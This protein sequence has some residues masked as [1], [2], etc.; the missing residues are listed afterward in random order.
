MLTSGGWAQEASRVCMARAETI[1]L[2]DSVFAPSWVYPEG[3]I[4]YSAVERLLDQA[5]MALTGES[6][7]RGAWSQLFRPNDRVG[8]QLD[9][10]ALPVHQALLEAVMRRLARAGVSTS[11]IIVYAGE[12]SALFNAGYALRRGGDGVQV[13]GTDAEGFRGGLSRI[14]LDYCTAIINLARLRVDPQVG[15]CG[16]LANSL[17]A[18]PHV[19]RAR[20]Q[21][22]PQDLAAAAARATLRR[23]TKL[24]ILDALRPGHMA[25]EEDGSPETW[26]YRG[27]LVSYDPVA[28]DAVGR[29]I[30]L[31]KFRETNQDVSEL[32]PPV[33]YLK[34]ASERYRLGQHDLA[35]I[36]VVTTGL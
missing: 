3:K 31:D 33:A 29:S 32:Q 19:E 30:L 24:C 4:D 34:P 36:E 26:L 7:V 12:E 13:M 25:G 10:G 23:N 5:M 16:V 28:L 21:R 1:L 2:P 20:L 17:A 15:M 27:V 11:N 18:V 9:V 8:I 35:K 22:S 14:V 6:A